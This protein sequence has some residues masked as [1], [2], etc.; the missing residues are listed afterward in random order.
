MEL[1]QVCCNEKSW[2]I[3]GIASLYREIRSNKIVFAN[4]VDFQQRFISRLSAR[5]AMLTAY[6]NKKGDFDARSRESLLD[7]EDEWLE[8]DFKE[9]GEVEHI[10]KVKMN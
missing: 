9:N 4:I 2:K 10:Y 5:H 7:G 8:K 6:V 3:P 1:P